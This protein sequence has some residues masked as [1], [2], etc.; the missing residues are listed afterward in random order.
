M[1]ELKTQWHPA[2]ACL[3][4]VYEEHID[5]VRLDDITITLVR[6]TI[7]SKYLSKENQKWLTLLSSDLNEE[8][9]ERVVTQ[10]KSLTQN[11]E[12]IYGDSVLQ[13]AL[14]EN[15]RIFNKV[16]EDK[17]MCEA[18]RKLMEPEMNEALE[19]QRKDIISKFLNAGNSVE[20]ISRIM[21]VPLDEVREIEKELLQMA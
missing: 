7:V 2:F 18:L 19:K 1:N 15:E 6:E 14:K 10:V 8:D 17:D 4:K 16:K 13:V 20:E 5:E 9:A 21:Q 3:Y 11:A 12:K